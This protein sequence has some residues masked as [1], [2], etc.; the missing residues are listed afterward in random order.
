M[1]VI[2]ISITVH[3]KEFVN[4]ITVSSAKNYTGSETGKY[5]RYETK[6]LS[7]QLD[8]R[9]ITINENN[10]T[11]LSGRKLTYKVYDADLNEITMNA[12]GTFDVPA[13]GKYLIEVSNLTAADIGSVTFRI[14]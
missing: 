10:S 8:A 1:K 3:N 6:Y 14:V 12:D 5:L 2:Y 13:K 4:G 11:V 7:A 9:K